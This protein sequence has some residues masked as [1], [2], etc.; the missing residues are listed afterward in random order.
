VYLEVVAGHGRID[1][2]ARHAVGVL[3]GHTSKGRPK[4]SRAVIVENRVAA[5]IQVGPGSPHLL[6][7]VDVCSR[8]L[9]ATQDTAAIVKD[10]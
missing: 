3:V 8:V 9:P 1:L 2:A 7:A 4:S 5:C 6:T 10:H